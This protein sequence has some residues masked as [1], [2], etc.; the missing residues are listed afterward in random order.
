MRRFPSGM[1]LPVLGGVLLLAAGLR[2]AHVGWGLPDYFFPDTDVE[3]IV[4]TLQH[5]KQTALPE[6]VA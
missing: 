4:D 5:I 2:L 6:E 1:P 3:V